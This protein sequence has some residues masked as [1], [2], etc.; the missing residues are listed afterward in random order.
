MCHTHLAFVLRTL[1]LKDKVLRVCPTVSV[2]KKVSMAISMKR[3][4][5]KNTNETYSE[6]KSEDPLGAWLTCRP[7]GATRHSMNR[8]RT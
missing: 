4:I 7:Q 3:K 1:W 8:K 6:R 5:Q 2:R